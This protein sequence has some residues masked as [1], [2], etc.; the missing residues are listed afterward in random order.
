MKWPGILLRTRLYHILEVLTGQDKALTSHLTN[1]HARTRAVKTCHVL[2]V[3]TCS[4][5]WASRNS[6][7]L[8]TI[9]W[10]S[11]FVQFALLL[12]I[13][14]PT[15]PF[16]LTN[17]PVRH[18]HGL[19]NMEVTFAVHVLAPKI[20]IVTVCSCNRISTDVLLHKPKQKAKVGCLPHRHE[21][22]WLLDHVL[23]AA[24]RPLNLKS[25]YPLSKKE[26]KLCNWHRLTNHSD[27][28]I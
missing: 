3:G 10:N 24:Y 21:C 8:H 23:S 7:L 4:L 20:N 27:G 22:V 13:C 6:R 1:A 2:I 15:T 5:L 28:N 16:I 18:T 12:N 19:R 11:A 14:G 25:N 26:K 9:Y 17:W